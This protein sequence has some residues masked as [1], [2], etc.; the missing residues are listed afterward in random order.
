MIDII[1]E[2]LL[3]GIM[4]LVHQVE[5]ATGV[6]QSDA[7]TTTVGIILGEIGVLAGEDE[8]SLVLFQSDIDTRVAAATD[9]MLEGI[10]D[11]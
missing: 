4:P 1:F 8:F 9:A 5:A 3:P 7:R 10:L 6:L 11:E 2:R